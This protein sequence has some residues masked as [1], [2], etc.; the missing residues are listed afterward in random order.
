[1]LD[2]RR[3]HAFHFRWRRWF[4]HAA[5]RRPDVGG[6]TRRRPTTAATIYRRT[7]QNPSTR[8]RLAIACRHHTCRYSL[9]FWRCCAIVALQ[10][11]DA[12]PGGAP[13][14][15]PL[16]RGTPRHR[17]HLRG[18]EHYHGHLYDAFH[19]TAYASCCTLAWHVRE[20]GVPYSPA[21]KGRLERLGRYGWRPAALARRPQGICCTSRRGRRPS[22]VLVRLQSAPY[23]WTVR[24]LL[25]VVRLRNL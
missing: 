17:L 9:P 1:M 7:T 23:G 2:Y 22:S 4:T 14:V 10:A 24:H 19:C 12:R 18:V 21:A 15:T 13:Q 8:P 6:W 5:A 20:N 16:P 25:A 11:W 3:G